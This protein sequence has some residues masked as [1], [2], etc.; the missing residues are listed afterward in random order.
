MD[1]GHLSSRSAL[2]IERTRPSKSLRHKENLAMPDAMT[3]RRV[4]PRYPLILLAEVTDVLSSSKLA[5]RTSDL[6]R[7][8]CYIDM[9]N[10]LPRGT[11]VHVRL[12]NQKEVFESTATVMYVSPGLGIG[13][14][15]AE[16]LSMNQLVLLD[17]WLAAAAKASR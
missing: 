7:T 15:F 5:A 6:S 2:Q 14:A 16:N 12:Q 1:V 4:A 11:K 3:D 9:L 13:V 10:P 8:G 17:R